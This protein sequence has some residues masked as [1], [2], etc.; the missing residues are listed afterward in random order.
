MKYHTQFLTKNFS[1]LKYFFILWNKHRIQTDIDQKSV[2]LKIKFK[3]YSLVKK[4]Y[5]DKYITSI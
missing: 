2:P 3:K 5:P 4:K 1:L